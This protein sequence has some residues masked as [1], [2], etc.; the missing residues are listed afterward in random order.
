M[1][2]LLKCVLMLIGNTCYRYNHNMSTYMLG[3]VGLHRFQVE[4]HSA[5]ANLFT[6]LTRVESTLQHLNGTLTKL[7]SNQELLFQKNDSLAIKMKHVGIQQEKLGIRQKKQRRSLLHLLKRLTDRMRNLLERL[8]ALRI[9][10]SR[11]QDIN[12]TSWQNKTS[13]PSNR[14]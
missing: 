12:L 8:T 4:E 14:I 3:S 7:A 1:S 5:E 11:S 13:W 6:F 10:C 9:V 2:H